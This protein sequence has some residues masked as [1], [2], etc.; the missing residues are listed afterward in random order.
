LTR[1]Q[2]RQIAALD[3][4]DELSVPEDRLS[5]ALGVVAVVA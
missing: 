4:V 5:Q 1:S 2:I 3:L